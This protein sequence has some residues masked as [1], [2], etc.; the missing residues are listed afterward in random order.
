MMRFW[1]VF[2]W[3]A[4]GWALVV[5]RGAGVLVKK[6]SASRRAETDT[7]EQQSGPTWRR[8]STSVAYPGRSVRPRPEPSGDSGASG[9]VFESATIDTP[10]G[11]SLAA[12][13]FEPP[14]ERLGRV[15]VINSAMGVLQ[16]FYANYARYLA[17]NGFATVTYDYRGIGGSVS[18]GGIRRSPAT[19]RDW[20]RDFDAVLDRVEDRWPGRPVVVVGHSVGGQILG[21]LP[22]PERVHALLGVA[23]Q[24]GY[25][26]LW[27]GVGRLRIMA[28]W[29]VLIPAACA[30]LGYLPSLLFGGGEHIPA[31]VARQW[32]Q[33][34]RQRRYIADRFAPDTS[35]DRVE[36]PMRLIGFAD[37]AFAPRR[38]VDGLARLYPAATVEQCRVEP[39]S[40]HGH[41]IGHFGFFRPRMKD[42]LWADSVAWL[43]E[44]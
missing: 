31:G 38:A 22:Q 2:A 27:S 36:L 24:S 37:D 5:R 35:F 17:E 25:W 40:E 29:Y 32:A 33:A 10:D 20:G 7:P 19:L 16:R 23:A 18:S 30:A 4:L 6:R 41:E 11:T 8:T 44:A 26:K 12:T 43:R 9:A 34:G 13:I 28:L 39:G 42:S 21:L 3:I 1:K 14:G 15:V